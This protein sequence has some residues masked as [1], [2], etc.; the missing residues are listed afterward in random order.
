MQLQM[1]Y[2]C[3]MQI[4][5]PSPAPASIG[6]VDCT[7]AKVRRLA[8]RVSQIYDDALAP[9]GLT[10]GQM[11]LLASLRRREG[12]GVRALA[13]RLSADASTVSRLLKPLA[14]A[15]Y[16]RIDPDP[17]DARAKQVRLTDAG[18]AIR[19]EAMPGWLAA[20]AH[21]RDALGPGRL[22]ALRF[23][24]DDAHAHL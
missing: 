21:M 3:A 17:D 20:Q 1:N 14:T 15:G 2:V 19:R 5:K 24:L 6:P 7:A 11:G 10:I 22:D 23:L 4:I 12:V 18:Y 9:H 8:R 13:D 16:L